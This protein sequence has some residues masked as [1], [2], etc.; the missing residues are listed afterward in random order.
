M[1]GRVVEGSGLENRQ[2]GDPL[3]GSNPTPSATYLALLRLRRSNIASTFNPIY[4]SAWRVG[5]PRAIHPAM[6]RRPSSPPVQRPV[7]EP[8][9]PTPDEAATPEQAAYIE[10]ERLRRRLLELNP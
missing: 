1:G 7:R 3:V 10:G 2:R 5:P 8:P 6:P 9:A 4:R